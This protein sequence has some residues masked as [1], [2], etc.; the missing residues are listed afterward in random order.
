[1]AG[2]LERLMIHLV[3]QWHPQVRATAI[4]MI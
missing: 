3:R 2:R 4:A 1:V